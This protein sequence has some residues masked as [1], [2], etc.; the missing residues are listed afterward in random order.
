MERL[1]CRIGGWV[2]R[3]RLLPPGPK[4]VIVDPH[5]KTIA[6]TPNTTVSDWLAAVAAA[7]AD[8]LHAALNPP[9]QVRSVA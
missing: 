7:E 4:R 1:S 2:A 6:V 8:E 5:E 3:F 9:R